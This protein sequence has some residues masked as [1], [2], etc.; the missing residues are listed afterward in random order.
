MSIFSNKKR[1]SAPIDFSSLLTTMD[2]GQELYR[3]LKIR[4]HPDR[5][6]GMAKEKAAEELFKLVQENSTSYESLLD[7][8]VRIKN[9]LE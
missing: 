1:E 8:Q 2:K 3:K 7:L 9:E 6:V 5:F 4:C